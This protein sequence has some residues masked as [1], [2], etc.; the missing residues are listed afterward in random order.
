MNAAR[1]VGGMDI[2]GIN[3]H[4]LTGIDPTRYSAHV[5]GP[6]CT[7]FAFLDGDAHDADYEKCH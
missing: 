5:N 4:P 7:T 3:F 6:W 2:P 1:D